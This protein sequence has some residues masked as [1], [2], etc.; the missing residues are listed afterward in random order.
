MRHVFERPLYHLSLSV[1]FDTDKIIKKL[2][3]EQK[4]QGKMV[5]YISKHQGIQLLSQN[6]YSCNFG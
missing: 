5:G 6:S 2:L 4:N 3:E 1:L